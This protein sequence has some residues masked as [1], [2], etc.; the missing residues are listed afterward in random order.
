M[1]AENISC[2]CAPQLTPDYIHLQIAAEAARRNMSVVYAGGTH[3]TGLIPFDNP[4]LIG[5]FCLIAVL[6][7]VILVCCVHLHILK[8]K[9]REQR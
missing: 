8:K 9:E 7:G 5:A 1:I 4:Y 3:P 2:C 6:I